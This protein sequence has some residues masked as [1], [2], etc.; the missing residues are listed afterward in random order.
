MRAF[1]AEGKP[2][3]RPKAGRAAAVSPSIRPN[4]DHGQGEWLLY[5][6]HVVKAPSA[7]AEHDC[8]LAGE[9]SIPKLMRWGASDVHF[10]IRYTR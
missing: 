3:K 8:Q 10:K 4:V 7:A 6:A 9:A 2:T 5:R 1:D